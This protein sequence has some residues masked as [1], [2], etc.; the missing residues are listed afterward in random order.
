[1]LLKPHEQVYE[2]VLKAFLSGQ[3]IRKAL[4]KSKSIHHLPHLPLLME[5]HVAFN[6]S[7]KK[8][9][10]VLQKPTPLTVWKEVVNKDIIYFVKKNPLTEPY[11]LYH[12]QDTYSKP[13]QLYILTK[14]PNPTI[15]RLSKETSCYT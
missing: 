8:I 1:M 12:K 4:Y 13:Q 14:L 5:E 10:M 11:A 2:W 9:T 3:K 7:H 15:C 6:K